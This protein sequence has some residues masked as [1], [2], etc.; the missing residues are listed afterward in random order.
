MGTD[1]STNHT[2][3][4]KDAE[5]HTSQENPRK[6][7]G[8]PLRVR[9]SVHLLQDF[10]LPKWFQLASLYIFP[11]YSVYTYTTQKKQIYQMEGLNITKQ[12]LDTW[13]PPGC[14]RYQLIIRR[15]KLRNLNTSQLLGPRWVK[16][17]GIIYNH[18]SPPP[19][20]SHTKSTNT[21]L[22]PEVPR[23]AKTTQ[24]NW[25][26]GDSQIFVGGFFNGVSWFP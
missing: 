4:N 17:P 3:K 1:R 26:D 15:S 2:T 12:K 22:A 23:N 24:F 6:T 16:I 5:S 9:I 21:S 10:I 7:L 8:K 11:C 14:N 18:P 19:G 25:N 13:H 20:A